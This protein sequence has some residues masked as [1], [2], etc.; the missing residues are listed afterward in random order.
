MLTISTGKG[1][2]RRA[3]LTVGSTLCR[4][5]F[6]AQTGKELIAQQRFVFDDQ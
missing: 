5:A 4:V 2:N 6:V 3:F 1:I